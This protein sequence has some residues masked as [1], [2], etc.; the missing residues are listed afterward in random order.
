M[1]AHQI[2][3]TLS[4][5]LQRGLVPAG[6]I[7]AAKVTIEPG[8][9]IWAISQDNQMAPDVAAR[10]HGKALQTLFSF[11]VVP[12]PSRALAA[13]RILNFIQ[14]G[15]GV[16]IVDD[17]RPGRETPPRA[18][19]PYTPFLTQ[20]LGGLENIS[21]EMLFGAYIQAGYFALEMPEL[22]T[23]WDPEHNV[24]TTARALLELAIERR[25]LRMIDCLLDMGATLD[26][27]PFRTRGIKGWSLKE[28]KAGDATDFI[29][30]LFPATVTDNAG[31][32]RT[33]ARLLGAAMASRMQ[34]EIA[35]T[36]LSQSGE[37]VSQGL[38]K[39]P[40]RQGL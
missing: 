38:A 37:A 26:N 5:Q 33:R 10:Q 15:A 25:Q 40:R 22:V 34:K 30:S 28:V 29:E 9:L 17:S 32:V 13:C 39:H 14:R 18:V 2:R 36:A 16:M 4:E 3:Q 11:S 8:N 20:M 23:S 27:I 7:N 12:E 19:P 31:M 6:L 24:P 1:S 21:I 35:Q